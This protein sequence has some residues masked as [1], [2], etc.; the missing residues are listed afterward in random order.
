MKKTNSMKLQFVS[1]SDNEGF[2]R[3]AV[4]GFL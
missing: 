4:S 1:R 2:D 3:T